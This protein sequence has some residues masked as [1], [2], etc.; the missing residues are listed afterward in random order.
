M[1]VKL[2]YLSVCKKK[3]EYFRFLSIMIWAY[4]V[5]FIT[6]YEEI[7]HNFFISVTMFFG[8]FIGSATPVGGG[9]I[10]FPVLTLIKH[11]PP[12]IAAT[13]SLAIQ[14]FGMTAASL[15]I[16]KR[17]IE[18]DKVLLLV[19]VI[20]GIIGYSASF[21]F[22]KNHISP[23]LLKVFFS[24]FWLSFGIVL[25]FT[26][27]M[28]NNDFKSFRNHRNEIKKIVVFGICSL[29]GGMITAWVGSSMDV[30]FFS[31]AILLFSVEEK[32]ATPTSVIVMASLSLYGTVLN[33]ISNN[34]PIDVYNYLSSTIPIV[35]YLAPAGAVFI[36]K[37]TNAYIRK[38]VYALIIF[39]Y[40]ST[41]TILYDKKVI[42]F[43]LA[44]VLSSILII[45]M[46]KSINKQEESGNERV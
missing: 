45:L 43:S 12:P 36:S 14:S 18:F 34:I 15:A 13:Y 31:L 39:Q 25:F 9:A 46:V 41:I 16:M 27:K 44:V 38:I 7:F 42:F 3:L 37:R 6:G 11:T 10:A 40:I 35:I 20:S 29:V 17:K 5:I 23:L 4:I 24:S 2:V 21:F 30:I 8:A 28:G 19:S 22:I 33:L 26:N 1:N 32:I